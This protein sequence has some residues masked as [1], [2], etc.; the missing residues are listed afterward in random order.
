[1]LRRS[2]AGFQLGEQVKIEPRGKHQG[3]LSPSTPKQTLY[4][5]THTRH[6]ISHAGAHYTSTQRRN[7]LLEQLQHPRLQ[8][9]RLQHPI[10][11]SSSARC[12]SGS[13]GPTGVRHNPLCLPASTVTVYKEERTFVETLQ[14]RPS[15]PTTDPAPACA[16]RFGV[17]SGVRGLEDQR[18]RMQL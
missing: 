8:H 15:C 10:P 1:M 2:G 17:C 5:Q 18:C 13:E 12:S 14:A 3:F 9:P 7:R 6:S 11:S 16:T 4:R